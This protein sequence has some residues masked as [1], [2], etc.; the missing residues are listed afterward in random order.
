MA[1][2]KAEALINSRPL[3]YQSANLNDNLPLTPNHFLHGQMGG[4]FAQE[5]MDEIGYDPK[6][7]WRRIQELVR[8]LWYQW[9]R[10]W[11]PIL[12]PR[13][14]WFKLKKDL[15]PGDCILMITPSTPRGQRP[16]GRVM[17]VWS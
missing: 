10:E 6:R 16:L 9:L 12:S 3:T 7:Q 13:E 5:V 14:K 15:K 2:C 8:H 1:F 4:Q 17:E 11:I